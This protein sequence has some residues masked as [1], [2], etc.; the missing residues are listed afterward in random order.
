MEPLRAATQLYDLLLHQA[1]ST[2]KQLAGCSEAE[3][4]A[5]LQANAAFSTIAP[6]QTVEILA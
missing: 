1:L 4:I 3:L 2:V 6:E 5:Q